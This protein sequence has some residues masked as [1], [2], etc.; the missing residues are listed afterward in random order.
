MT[1]T[2]IRDIFVFNFRHGTEERKNRRDKEYQ[3]KLTVMCDF[4]QSVEKG[5]TTP[6]IGLENK[7]KEAFPKAKVYVEGGWGRH[8]LSIVFVFDA[9]KPSQILSEQEAWE[10]NAFTPDETAERIA[11]ACCRAHAEWKEEQALDKRYQDANRILGWAI[12]TFNE[13][14]RLNTLYKERL[15]KLEEEYALA[16]KAAY[17]A[18]WEETQKELLEKHTEF[19]ARAVEVAMAAAG[20]LVGKKEDPF[21]NERMTVTKD[22]LK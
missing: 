18:G 20:D 17:N 10:A 5:N 9:E 11:D 14:A 15:Q 1:P 8:S 2:I 21:H 13:Q 12:R 16:A 22:L 4:T 7:L 3:R 19:D 6:F